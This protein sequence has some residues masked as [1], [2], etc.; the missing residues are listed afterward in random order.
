VVIA[1]RSEGKIRE[2]VPILAS[3]GIAATTLSA[4]GLQETTIEAE[5]EQFDTFE[6]N[7][8]AKAQYFASL[9]PGEIVIADDSGLVVDA[10]G[11]RPGVASKRWSARPDLSGEALDD[12]NNAR[13][14]E[15]LRMVGAVSL[16]ERSARYICAMASYNTS[17]TNDHRVAVGQCAGRILSA[18]RGTGGFG[19]DPFFWSHDLGAAFGEVTR[20]AKATVSHRARA[21]AQLLDALDAWDTRIE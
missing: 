5:L 11:G 17:N 4:R 14:Q 18:P 3:R 8:V 12:A 19:Y 1:T 16:S 6:S 20:E 15:E 9:L 2:L 7:A 10:L 21:L 13:L